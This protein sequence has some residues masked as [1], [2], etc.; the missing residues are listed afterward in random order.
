MVGGLAGP[1]KLLADGGALAF[2]HNGIQFEEGLD[3]LAKGGG[4]EADGTLGDAGR[5]SREG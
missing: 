5:P 3:V 1:R 2:E 4:S